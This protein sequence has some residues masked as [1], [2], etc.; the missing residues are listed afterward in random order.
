MAILVELATKQDVV[1]LDTNAVVWLDSP[2]HIWSD[3]TGVGTR[4][5][6]L[7]GE[8][9]DH[10]WDAY[11]ESFAAPQYQI[12]TNY[13]GFIRMGFGQISISLDAFVDDGIPPKQFIA[14]TK[15]TASTES[16]A[17]ELLSGTIYLKNYNETTAI[18]QMKDPKYTQNLLDIG[19]D[20]NGDTVPYPKAFGIVTHVTP[21]RLANVGAGLFNYHLGGISTGSAAKTITAFSSA[22][23]GTKTKVFT[24]AAHGWSN[25]DSVYIAGTINFD[26][27]HII[28]SVTGTSFIIPITYLTDNSEALPLHA[29][30]Y[31]LGDFIVFDDGVPIQENVDLVT[32]PPGTFSLTASPVGT[33]TISGTGEDTTL[34]EVITWGYDRL[35]GLTSM[36]STNARSISPDLAYWATSQVPLIDFMS[37]I[38]E[39]FTHYFFI[40]SG[41]LTLG[42]MLLD[43]GADDATEYDYFDVNYKESEAINQLTSSWTTFSAEN[44]FVD[45]VRTAR[46]IQSNENKV[47][48]SLHVVS[49]GTSNSTSVGFLVDSDA[50]FST[51]GVEDGDVVQNTTDNTST[52]VISVAE[53]TLGLEDDIFVSGENYVVGPS[54]PY[55]KE[56]NITPYHDNKSN[57][58]DALTNILT[59]LNKSTAEIRMPI[60]ATLPDP[61]KKFTFADSQLLVDMSTYIRSRILTYDFASEEIIIEGEGVIS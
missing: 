57:V 28:E 29:S 31:T 58:L 15:Y 1:W 30:A 38:C 40:K 59:I 45:E 24:F 35:G 16:A 36:V 41:T 56:I 48:K 8:A 6:S 13:G 44:G 3:G 32:G 26:G 22:A 10:Y 23:S 5:L 37:A 49:S 54:Y 27:T 53:T 55:G 4:Y 17:V 20:Y 12:A 2:T 33:V 46:F 39:F 52:T 9:L 11:I 14:T 34:K 47:V 19:A 50:T 60:T 51:D 21:I 42:D 61:G 43:D 18:Y 7:D 25:G